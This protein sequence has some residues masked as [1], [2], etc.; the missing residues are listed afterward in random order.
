MTTRHYRSADV[1]P[2]T[3]VIPVQRVVTVAEAAGMQMWTRPARPTRSA[4]PRRPALP[5]AGVPW[6]TRAERER[7][8]HRRRG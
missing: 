8:R 2:A 7:G 3:E 1:D 6:P 4:P 5:S